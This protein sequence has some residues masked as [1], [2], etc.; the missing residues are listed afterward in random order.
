[1]EEVRVLCQLCRPML[2]CRMRCSRA[3]P[4]CCIRA[5][6]RR[7]RLLGVLEGR[8]TGRQFIMGDD[9]T[10]ADIAIFPW[11]A[12]LSQFYKARALCAAAPGRS[13]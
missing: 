5:F 10:I 2:R 8:L 4:L 6:A 9:Y 3:C 13:P 11:V 7:Q 1:M 12:A